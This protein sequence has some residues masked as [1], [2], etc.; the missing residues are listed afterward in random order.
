MSVWRRVPTTPKGETFKDVAATYMKD[1]APQLSI[2]TV[3]QDAACSAAS[4]GN[5]HVA[6][7]ERAEL[8]LWKY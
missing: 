1:I 4:Y 3:R 7:A 2:A 6:D 5:R 8:L